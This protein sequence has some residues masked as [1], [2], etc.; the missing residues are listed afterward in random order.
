MVRTIA[1]C[2]WPT[3]HLAANVA[4]RAAVA[5]WAAFASV[6]CGAN[7]QSVYEGDV[8]F[9]HC[10]RLDEDTAVP[11]RHKWAC[12]REWNRSYAYGQSRERTEYGLAR[13]RTLASARGAPTIGAAPSSSGGVIACPTPTNAFAPPPP[14][15]HD[16]VAQR[17][18]PAGPAA[19][20]SDAPSPPASSTLHDP[21]AGKTPGAS[22]SDSCTQD[23]SHCGQACSGAK[24]RATCDSQ[25]RACMHHCF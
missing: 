7:Y 4:V 11:V 19:T 2:A 10:Y 23:W 17:E 8:R 14:M 3:A 5:A 13:E 1:P 16:G 18:E 6:G 24:C 15:L 25:Y 9:E 21:S 22:C 12:W 20:A